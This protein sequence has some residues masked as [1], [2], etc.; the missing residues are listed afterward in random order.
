VTTTFPVVAPA[1]TEARTLVAA[2][3]IGS[4]MVP[5]NVTVLDPWVAP[6]LVPAIVTIVPTTPVVGARIVTLGVA[7]DVAVGDVLEP[8]TQAA[9]VS[10]AI[11]SATKAKRFNETPSL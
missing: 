10:A 8:L 7:D 6:K 3:A 5:L 9:V 1:G 2:H 4:T 11:A